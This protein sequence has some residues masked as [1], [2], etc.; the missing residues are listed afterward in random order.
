MI[1]CDA[2][3]GLIGL[4]SECSPSPSL[5][6]LFFLSSSLSCLLPR[7]PDPLS[8]YLCIPRLHSLFFIPRLHLTSTN[9]MSN[10]TYRCR[11]CPLECTT[12]R[13]DLTTEHCG[14]CQHLESL[15]RSGNLQ[16]PQLSHVMVCYFLLT[17]E[18]LT[19]A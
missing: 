15:Q 13:I 9:K 18:I 6:S 2:T 5:L 11:N 3:W 16:L 14:R 12:D 10:I 19:D 8:L 1:Q 7:S 4:R 17:L